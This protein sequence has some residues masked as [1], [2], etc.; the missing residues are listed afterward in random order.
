MVGSLFSHK[1]VI[2][3]GGAVQGCAESSLGAK[4]FLLVLS[5]SC[6]YIYQTCNGFKQLSVCKHDFYYAK[7]KKKKKKYNSSEV[8]INW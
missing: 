4:V 7:K 6:S 3:L 2:R 8:H 5:R 1:A